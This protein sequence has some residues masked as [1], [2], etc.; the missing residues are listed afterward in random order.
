M[1]YDEINPEQQWLYDSSVSYLRQALEA[2][3]SGRRAKAQELLQEAMYY[4]AKLPAKFT[5]VE[6]DENIDRITKLIMRGY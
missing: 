5:K 2:W 4:N 3:N 6:H 1:N